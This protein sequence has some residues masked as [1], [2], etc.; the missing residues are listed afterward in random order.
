MNAASVREGLR[1]YFTP[2]LILIL[3]LGFASGLPLLLTSSTLTIRLR[4]AGV[5][6]GAIGFFSL[7]GIPYSLK[8][9]WAPLLDRLPLPGIT[10][11]Y[12][13]RRGWML[14]IHLGLMAAI[15][16][17]GSVD[18]MTGG[19]GIIAVIAILVSFL[20]AT[21]DIAIDA[22]RI[23]I[24]KESEF[25]A[26]AAMAVYGFRGGMLMATVGTLY[27]AEWF[28]WEIAYQV[29]AATLLIGVAAILLAPEPEASGTVTAPKSMGE[30]FGQAYWAPLKEFT[31]R[32]GWLLLLLFVLLFKFG[33]ALLSQ[34]A[35]A[36]YVDLGF[37]KSTIAEVGK[38]YGFIAVM[39]G[40][41][42]GGLAVVTIGLG[43]TLLIAG[44]LQAISNLGY[45]RLAEAGNDV[46]MLAWVVGFENLATGLG[47]T[48]FVAFL[49]T[50]CDRRYTA[51]Q[52]ALLTSIVAFSPK[53][54]VAPAGLMAESL[55]WSVFC[56]A[57]AIAAIPG[58]LLLLY[59]LKAYPET[60]RMTPLK[61]T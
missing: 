38:L 22:Y 32:D 15:A 12:G 35:G 8:F 36:F 39:V 4:E 61:E 21:Q 31:A 18:P 53:V 24:L 51:A 33:D 40:T 42:L 52:F 57:T 28:D 46:T 11:R 26:G 20:S 55:G 45:W 47:Q 2:R 1:V 37:E 5:D 58:I 16:A 23:E 59:L 56:L 49:M 43:R 48:A 10:S 13:R 30:L 7:V 29:T 6:L 25:G 3:V 14:A 54:L 50:L 9:L 41:F 19:V 60:W 44:F 27:L 34:M 17:L